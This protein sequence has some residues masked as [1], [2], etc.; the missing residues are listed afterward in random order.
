RTT[1]VIPAGKI[2]NEKPITI[3]S[4]RWYSPKLLIYVMTRRDDPR[5]GTVIYRVTH[6]KLGEP[7]ADLFSVPADYRIEQ[8]PPRPRLFQRQ[9]R[10]QPLPAQ[11]D[12]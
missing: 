1:R 3:V 10:N 12:K 5:F 8:G 9:L 7:S 11:P 6:L 4:E 2:G